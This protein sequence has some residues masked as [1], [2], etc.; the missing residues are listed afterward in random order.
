MNQLVW[1]SECLERAFVI[2]AAICEGVVLGGK[3][4][5][6]RYTKVVRSQMKAVLT[7]FDRLVMIALGMVC[8]VLQVYLY[9]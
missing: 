9:S 4:G 6:C 7:C 1:W 5:G 2:S 8:V 3:C